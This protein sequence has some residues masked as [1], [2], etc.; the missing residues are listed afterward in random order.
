VDLRDPERGSQTHPLPRLSSRIP[1]RVSYP[2]IG[3]FL[4]LGAPL[5]AAA[6]R[7]AGGNSLESE[8]AEH[9]FF[10]IYQLVGTCLVFAAAGLIAGLRADRLRRRED[11]YHA[12]SDQDFLTRLPNARAFENRYGRTLE[13]AARFGEPVSLLLVDVDRLKSINDEFGHEIGSA[14]LCHVARILEASKRTEDLAA[15]WGGDEFV[16]LMPAADQTAA[17]RVGQEIL[18]RMNRRPFSKGNRKF[19]FTVTIGV[20]TKMPQATGADLF[21]QA[22]RALLK[23]KSAG[24]NRLQYPS[25]S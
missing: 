4:G 25:A 8:L 22:D 3:A 13:R 10:Y 17:E 24:G 11:L 23:G 15:R 5:G 16:I 9:L 14:A 2:I 1:A 21:E 6:F 20:S 18:Q 12:L 7:L 19:P